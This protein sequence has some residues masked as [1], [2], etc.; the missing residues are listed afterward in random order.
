MKKFIKGEAHEYP[1]IEIQWIPGQTPELDLLNI[2]KQVVK[3]IV[4]SPMSTEAIR[5]LLASHGITKTSPKP[6]YVA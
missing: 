3:K 1:A 2:R 4:L 5:E 6:E